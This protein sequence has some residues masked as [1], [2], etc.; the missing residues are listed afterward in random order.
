LRP[1]G[2]TRE[3]DHA[4]CVPRHFGEALDQLGLAP[5]VGGLGWHSRPHTRIQLT[6]ER[7]D[8]LSL[9]PSNYVTRWDRSVA[10]APRGQTKDVDR[11]CTR[12]EIAQ[13]VGDCF[14]RKGPGYAGCLQRR[15]T[16]R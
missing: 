4:V 9:L 14:A 3:E 1:A 7:L 5:S 8:Q 12:A 15:I 11:A 2:R 13:P 16:Q 10:L 6:P